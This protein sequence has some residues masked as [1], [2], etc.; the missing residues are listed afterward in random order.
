[1]YASTANKTR[2]QLLQIAALRF[3]ESDVVQVLTHA[4]APGIALS[5]FLHVYK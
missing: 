1:M 2:F 3:Y 4:H 5:L